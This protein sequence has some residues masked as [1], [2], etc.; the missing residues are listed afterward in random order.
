[1][2]LFFFTFSDSRDRVDN[3]NHLFFDSEMAEK[4]EHNS[5]SRA[6]SKKQTPVYLFV[7]SYEPA[8]DQSVCLCN[9][10][11]SGYL[12]LLGGI[13]NEHVMDTLF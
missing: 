6:V 8:V 10:C 2:K 11:Y 5:L 3:T 9:H 12:M 7:N 4:E 1:M 13:E